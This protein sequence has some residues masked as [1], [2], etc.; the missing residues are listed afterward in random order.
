MVLDNEFYGNQCWNCLEEVTHERILDA[1]KSKQ[2]SFPN[3]ESWLAILSL[4]KL[5]SITLPFSY[6]ARALL[7]L[8]HTEGK[9]SKGKHSDYLKAC[10]KTHRSFIAS[11]DIT[12][13]SGHYCKCGFPLP[14]LSYILLLLN[15]YCCR[16]DEM[17]NYSCF[18]H[19]IYTFAVIF[20]MVQTNSF[21]LLF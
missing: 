2:F 7:L 3:K 13:R 21:Q 6:M 20:L 14:F 18:P 4:Y 8:H 12:D 19:K 1:N 15:L 17:K 16:M 5:Y 10:S 11:S 9:V